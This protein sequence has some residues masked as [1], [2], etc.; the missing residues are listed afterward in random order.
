MN[1]H[2]GEQLEVVLGLAEGAFLVLL[3]SFLEVLKQVEVHLDVGG[4]DVLDQDVSKALIV[5]LREAVDEV[6]VRL[7][8]DV[9]GDCCV[10]LLERLEGKCKAWLR[11]CR[12]I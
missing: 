2:A 4:E 7:L 10:V 9:E 12:G 5:V 11:F 8:Q 3:Q 6:V 1:D